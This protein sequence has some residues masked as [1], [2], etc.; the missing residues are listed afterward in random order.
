[1]FWKQHVDYK[2][3]DY[4]ILYKTSLTGKFISEV[5]VSNSETI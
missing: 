5:W 2:D 4:R 1:M 3:K